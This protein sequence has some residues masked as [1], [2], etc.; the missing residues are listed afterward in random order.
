MSTAIEHAKHRQCDHSS[1]RQWQRKIKPP[2][3]L[4][5][6]PIRFSFHARQ[7]AIRKI[8]T[9]LDRLLIKLQHAP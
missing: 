5:N 2:P 4:M 9:D 8:H 7:K 1:G 3:N 6:P